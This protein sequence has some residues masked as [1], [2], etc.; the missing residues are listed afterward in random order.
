MTLL[1]IILLRF[2]TISLA[3]PLQDAQPGSLLARDH[4]YF[5]PADTSDVTAL[6]QSNEYPFCYQ[7]VYW[8]PVSVAQ[9]NSVLSNLRRRQDVDRRVEWHAPTIAFHWED[10]HCAVRLATPSEGRDWFSV[11]DIIETVE[12]ILR[13]C[14]GSGGVKVPNSRGG[15]E[16]IGNHGFRVLVS[17]RGFRID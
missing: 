2:L 3:H 8:P 16:D 6:N 9:C 10:V 7:N 17:G 13:S 5:L 12:R 4:K 1:L 11:F 15:S 14:Q